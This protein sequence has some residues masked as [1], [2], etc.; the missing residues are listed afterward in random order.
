MSRPVPAVDALLAKYGAAD[1]CAAE[2]LC[3]SHDPNAIAFTVVAAD[4]S[5]EDITYGELRER[6]ERG[7]AALAGLGIGPGDA[8]ATL[9]G[10]SM[11]LVV[12]LLAIWRRG[13]VHVPLFTAFAWPAI[14]LR[15]QASEAKA[16][17]TD[18]D[19]RAK[20]H[21]TPAA[22][23]VVGAETALPD[24]AL[25]PLLAAHE[26]G[27]PAEAVGGHG[28]MVLIFTSGTTGAP[29]GVPVPVRALAAFRQYI[30]LG[31][32]VSEDDV[33]W[34]AADP[35]WA[36]G[37][38][39]GILGPMA[40][41]RRNLL[42]RPGF[43]PELSFK[44]L[45]AFSV[46]NFAAAP[47]V[48]RTMRAK[49]PAGTAPF[50]LRRASSA[51]E[52]LTPEVI[53]WAREVLGVPVR[54]HYGQTEHGMM[55]INAWHDD[56]RTE[57]RPGSMGRPLPGWSCAVLKDNTDE[58]AAPGEMGRVAV[59]VAESPMMWFEAY[60]DAPEKTA[61]RF[62]QDGRWY[63]TGDAGMVDGDGYYY[64]SSR[65]DDVIIMAGYRIGP[66]EVESVLATHPAVLESAVVGA[67]DELRGEVLEAYVVL[68]AGYSGGD[69]LVAE[70]QTMV[71]TQFAAHAYP[72][73]IHF[74]DDLPKTPSGKLQRYILRQQRA[75]GHHS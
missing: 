3:D 47:T 30:E 44:V 68:G 6:S 29:K 39:Y 25:T 10:K 12:M 67:P 64:F 34:N 27:I 51:G 13:A 37:L 31:L 43:S 17:I 28:A 69:D 35:G 40:A 33:F 74:V 18:A 42:L 46:T 75:A 15:L 49:S 73:R 5:R 71:K 16:V 45:E 57:L 11:D 7:A 24:L 4:L 52:P 70:L 54:D 61:E 8:V 53:S 22:V 63:L 19:Q 50:Q 9:M 14:E 23:I 2:L 41:G 55:I 72:R 58:P 1:A 59:N 32:D 26:P 20:I 56:V 36:Y 21:D 48:Y 60:K 62:S 65:D 38:Y 66:F